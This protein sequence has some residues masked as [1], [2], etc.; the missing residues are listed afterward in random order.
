MEKSENLVSRDHSMKP[1]AYVVRVPHAISA[2][3]VQCVVLDRSLILW[4]GAAPQNLGEMQSMDEEDDEEIK[5]AMKAA[6]RMEAQPT[7][8]AHL[9]RDWGVA[10]NLNGSG[11]ISKS[12]NGTNLFNT[13]GTASSM[14]KRLAAKLGIPQVHLSLDLP[15]SWTSSMPRAS[16]DVRA[17]QLLEL[18]LRRVCEQALREHQA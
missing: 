12:T 9:A 4:C 11:N 13:Q 14:A 16:E 7:V 1:V 2:F 3:A 17:L 18:G 6:G 10:M 8:Q 5:E 15:E